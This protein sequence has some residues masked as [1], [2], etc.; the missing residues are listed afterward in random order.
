MSSHTKTQVSK[1]LDEKTIL[2]TRSFN[3]PLASVWRAYT[4]REL[5]DQWWGPEPWR[6]ETKFMNFREGGYWLYAMVGP[7][8]TRHWARMNY[9]NI[10]PHRV[11]EGEDGFCDENGVMN[12]ALPVNQ[13]VNTFI[14]TPTG[15]TVEHKLT[16]A[17]L[18]GLQTIVEMGFEQ[19]IS[20]GLDQLE[21]LLA[22]HTF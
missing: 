8:G 18:E 19:G 2:V 13:W 3:A 16:F 21:T 22:K 20:I 17:T 6:A 10:I 7:D 12:T 4:E 1:N 11:I 9:L 14:E 5:L 15:T